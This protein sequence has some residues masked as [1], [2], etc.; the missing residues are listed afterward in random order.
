MPSFLVFGKQRETF[1]LKHGPTRASA[2]HYGVRFSFWWRLPFQ[3]LAI[4]VA[5]PPSDMASSGRLVIS[6]KH[7]P[8]LV[9]LRLAC[10]NPALS[11]RLLGHP[12]LLFLATLLVSRPCRFDSGT[13]RSRRFRTS[14]C[15]PTA[16]LP[17]SHGGAENYVACRMDT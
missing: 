7:R 1:R 11:A 3:T 6:P 2:A 9:S 13:E 17:R 16:W 15:G 4:G 10:S 5:L 8:T 14:C 12:S